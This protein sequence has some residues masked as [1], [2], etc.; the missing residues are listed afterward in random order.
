MHIHEFHRDEGYLIQHYKLNCTN[1]NRLFT[2]PH[3]VRAQSTYKDIRI[4]SFHHTHTHNLQTL[5]LCLSVLW[6][7][8]LSF[9]C[10]WPFWNEFSSARSFETLLNQ[11][12][13]QKALQGFHV[14]TQSL[15]CQKTVR[16]AILGSTARLNLRKALWGFQARSFTALLNSLYKSA[17]GFLW[18][19]DMKNHWC[20]YLLP[21][22]E[23]VC[24]NRFPSHLWR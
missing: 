13:L 10:W 16:T 9:H 2:A 11:N 6:P 22:C 17:Y 24:E 20:W 18:K 12:A 7:V 23:S 8:K 5:P 21:I 19:L 1:N 15:H 14:V 3:L 4:R